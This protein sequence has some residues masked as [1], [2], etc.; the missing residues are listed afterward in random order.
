MRLLH[1]ADTVYASGLDEDEEEVATAVSDW[2]AESG[3]YAVNIYVNA[4]HVVVEDELCAGVLLAGLHGLASSSALSVLSLGYMRPSSVDYD[5][6][7]RVA[8]GELEVYQY[9]VGSNFS[10]ERALGED[11]PIALSEEVTAEDLDALYPEPEGDDTILGMP[12]WAFILVICALVLCCCVA[13]FVVAWNRQMFPFSYN[14]WKQDQAQ[15]K[16]KRART[17]ASNNIS[18]AWTCASSPTETKPITCWTI[19]DGYAYCV[20]VYCARGLLRA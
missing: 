8:F 9:A 3:E 1:G 17:G 16:G 14:K 11:S 18:T 20:W 7:S 19:G 15:S 10:M 5:G 12:L 2:D 6:D 4:T 13:Y